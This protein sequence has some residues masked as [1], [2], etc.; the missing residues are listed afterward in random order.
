MLTIACLTDMFDAA[1]TADDGSERLGCGCEILRPPTAPDGALKAQCTSGLQTGPPGDTCS[2]TLGCSGS[3]LACR[4]RIPLSRYP[5]G[6]G[7]PAYRGHPW[8]GGRSRRRSVSGARS[9]HQAS[10]VTVRSSITSSSHGTAPSQQLATR[11]Q[12][13]VRQGVNLDASPA[14]VMNPGRSEFWQVGQIIDV[15][16]CRLNVLKLHHTS[17]PPP[18]ARRIP[19]IATSIG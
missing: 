10:S 19:S 15:V 11:L 3:G 12:L 8:R 6:C 1:S 18:A 17:P 13:Y 9:D 2:T 14:A 4:S 16:L 7:A 5:R